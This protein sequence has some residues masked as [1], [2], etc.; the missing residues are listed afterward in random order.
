MTEY[1]VLFLVNFLKKS[2]KLLEPLPRFPRLEIILYILYYIYNL[3]NLGN[4]S[5]DFTRL[6]SNDL[7]RNLQD[8]LIK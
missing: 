6:G 4:G 7:Y 8:T 5:N 2:W 3:G 1:S